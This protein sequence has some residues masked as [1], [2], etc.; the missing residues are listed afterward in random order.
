MLPGTS[1]GHPL[2]IP[3][4]SAG[5]DVGDVGDV[6]PSSLPTRVCTVCSEPLDQ[7]LIDAGFTDHGG[8]CAS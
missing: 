3:A 7:A 1:V 2:D 8:G 5:E 4:V 6:V